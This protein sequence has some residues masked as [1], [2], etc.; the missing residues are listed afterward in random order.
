MSVKRIE[1]DISRRSKRAHEAEDLEDDPAK[2]NKKSGRRSVKSSRYNTPE[3]GEDRP[4]RKNSKKFAEPSISDRRVSKRSVELIALDNLSTLLDEIIKHKHAWP[5]L[6]PVSISEVPDY[7]DVIKS[8][9]DFG[10]IKSK[11]NLGSYR[12][13]EKMMRDIEQI[14]INCDLYNV[15]ASEIYE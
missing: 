3:P 8:P 9:M 11:L 6:K 7:L 12:S 4:S 10:K 14:F 13:N 5:F 15:A 1:V 2:T